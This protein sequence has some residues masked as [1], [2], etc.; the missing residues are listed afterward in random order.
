[1]KRILFAEEESDALFYFKSYFEPAG[2]EVLFA[3]KSREAIAM[4]LETKPDVA[5]I[6]I[7]LNDGMRGLDVIKEVHEKAPSQKMIAYTLHE[8]RDEEAKQA[9]ARFCLHKVCGIK[10]IETAIETVI[11]ENAAI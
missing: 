9:G 1:M 2:Y 8:T 11:K 4:I 5:I 3:V 10:E 6:D 7:W